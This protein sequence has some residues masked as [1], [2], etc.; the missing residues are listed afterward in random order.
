M[1]GAVDPFIGTE[2]TELPAPVGLAATWWSPKPQI[3]NTHPGATFPLG[4][5]SAC[6]YSGA[7]PTGYGRY[8]LSTE[9]VP[10]P[11]HD[12]QLASGLTH[13]QQS[14]TGAIRKYY[15]YFRVSPMVEPLDALGRVLGAARRGGRT[16]LVRRHAGHRHPL[17][18][19]RG[20]Q[21]RRPPLHL[22]APPRRPARRRLLPRRPADPLRQH[23]PAARVPRSP[24][25]PGSAQGEIVVE[26]APLAV[27]VECDA[28]QWRQLLW[29]DRRLMPGGTRLDFDS[30]RPTTLRPFGLMWAGPTR[31]GQTVEL[32][33]GFSL[34][35]AEQARANLYRDCVPG[36]TSFAARREATTQAWREHLDLV[37]V[38]RPH[39][40]ARDRVLHRPVPLAHQAVPGAGGEPVL[41]GAGP[42]RVRRQ[43]HVG[44]LPHAAAAADD[45]AARARRRAGPRPA[46][47]LR[48]GGQPAHRLPDG[49]GR[50]PVQPPGQRPR[51]HPARGPLRARAA[52]ARLGLGARAH[53]HRP[54]PR[55]R[56]GL[57]AARPGPPD[58]PHPRPG[59]WATGAPPRSPRARGR[60]R[61]GGAAR[62]A[63][64]PVGQ[65]LRPRDRACCTDSTFYEGG[66]W[67]YSFRLVHDMAA[68]IDLA[69]GDEALRRPRSTGS[70]ASG[71][72][73]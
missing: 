13:F 43:H 18:G 26:G 49:Q 41:A 54:A 47:R 30:I 70:S 69:G 48:G 3:G 19:D 62:A 44:H 1:I 23:R 22:P 61:A 20:P 40:R 8:D 6:A 11:I 34:R 53:A 21:E 29:Y 4:M 73:R 64:R 38:G 56:R 39:P 51:A 17:R 59:A 55:L 68:R 10:A 50:R 14:G 31:A 5:V 57:P 42:V 46:D 35:G 66:R 25:G 60:P 27:H 45:A 58:Q 12:R 24:S 28:D 7:Y 33:F 65:R 72:N 37:R 63:R 67:N 16:R 15:N 71:R 52:R 2:P 9:G 32:R 36:P